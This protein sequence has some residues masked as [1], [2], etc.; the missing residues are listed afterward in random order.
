MSTWPPRPATGSARTHPGVAALA[1]AVLLLLATGFADAQNLVTNPD[2]DTDLAGWSP[3]AEGTITWNELDSEGSALSG[4]AR[5]ETDPSPG[6][7]GASLEQCLPVVGGA[8]YDHDVQ[9]YRPPGGQGSAFTEIVWYAGAGCTS[10]LGMVS[11]AEF[12]AP[13][14]GTW[15]SFSGE[16]TAPAVASSA[17]LRLR[18]RREVPGAQVAHFDDVS[19]DPA[20]ACVDDDETLCLGAG[21]FRVRTTWD[22]TQGTS[23][24]GKAVRLT[25]DTGYFWFFG[26]ANVELVVKVLDACEPFDRFWVFA[27]G[28][29]NV[30]VVLTVDDLERGGSKTYENP[31]EMPFQPIQD[32]DAFATCP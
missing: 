1:G 21:R 18:V 19:L 7:G 22:T 31:Q 3:S 28:L 16:I 32:S 14:N 29:T 17:R 8:V 13:G 26:S 25:A 5:I 4:S 15:E 12:P 2:F 24:T 20:G 23:G 9:V 30:H 27:G 10:L 11:G 6:P